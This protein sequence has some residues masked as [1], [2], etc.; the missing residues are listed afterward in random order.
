MKRNLLDL[1]ADLQRLVFEFI[2]N[3]ACLLRCSVK[4]RSHGILW[5]LLL[6][7][8]QACSSSPRAL[9]LGFLPTKRFKFELTT[10]SSADVTSSYWITPGPSH[11]CVPLFDCSQPWHA[12]RASVEQY[13][14]FARH[15]PPARRGTRA[16]MASNKPTLLVCSNMG[17]NWIDFTRGLDNG[18]NL[19]PLRQHVRELFGV[20]AAGASEKEFMEG[21]GFPGWEQR[22][23]AVKGLGNNGNKRRSRGGSLQLVC[24]AYGGSSPP[25]QFWHKL[26]G[27]GKPS[28]KHLDARLT[29][30][31]LVGVVLCC[32]KHSHMDMHSF[33]SHVVCKLIELIGAER[34]ALL[35]IAIM[36]AGQEGVGQGEFAWEQEPDSAFSIPG[37]TNR[38]SFF[39]PVDH[40]PRNWPHEYYG[41][42][43]AALAWIK[44]TRRLL[45]GGV[46]GDEAQAAANP[47][48]TSLKG[49]TVS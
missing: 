16:K 6:Q 30:E 35:P 1:S 38:T 10:T 5:H 19:V 42:S 7:Y 47:A 20:E 36:T 34:F 3:T 27:R 33:R 25:N 8:A 22:W 39:N 29:M 14:Y 41:V 26:A 15:S 18:G 44:S 46:E 4:L 23:G 45:V 21:S 17:G 40:F 43:Q 9:E 49:C 31:S 2:G 13:L 12:H 28:K 24:C 48:P 32:S 11:A 37:W